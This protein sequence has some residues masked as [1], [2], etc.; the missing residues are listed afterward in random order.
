KAVAVRPAPS[1]GVLSSRDN[2]KVGS[3]VV[4]RVIVDMVNHHPAGVAHNQAVKE[5]GRSGSTGP[6]GR[7][8]SAL[9]A[10]PL[11]SLDQLGVVIVNEGDFP[12]AMFTSKRYLHR[13]SLA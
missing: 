1:T 12:G 11:I 6:I 7:N 4:Q 10:V 9:V 2:P 13:R 3:P 5:H 8:I